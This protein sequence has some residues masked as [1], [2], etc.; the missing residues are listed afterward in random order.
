[1]NRL[2]AK[3]KS[4]SIYNFQKYNLFSKYIFGGIAALN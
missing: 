1:M 3:T 2:K 4:S